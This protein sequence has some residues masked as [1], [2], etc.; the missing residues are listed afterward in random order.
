[1]A[2]T[3]NRALPAEEWLEQI[4][5]AIDGKDYPDEL[6]RDLQTLLR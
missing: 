3:P 4:R 2:T 6:V 5:Q 1:M